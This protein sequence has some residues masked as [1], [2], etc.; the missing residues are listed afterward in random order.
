MQSAD[1]GEFVLTQR[2]GGAYDYLLG[3][4]GFNI[5]ATTAQFDGFPGC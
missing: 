4:N 1:N 5:N 3:A 2:E